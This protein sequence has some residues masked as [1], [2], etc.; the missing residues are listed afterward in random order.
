MSLSSSARG[1]A[2]VIRCSPPGQEVCVL[3]CCVTGQTACHCVAGYLLA[4]KLHG[5]ESFC[6]GVLVL[7]IVLSVRNSLIFKKKVCVCMC[8]CVCVY[9]DLEVMFC[10]TV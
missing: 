3:Q 6:V 9:S 4:A 5:A 7:E 1:L 10:V 2:S 8:V